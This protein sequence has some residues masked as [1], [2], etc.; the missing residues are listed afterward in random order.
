MNETE[1]T[2][3]RSRRSLMRDAAVTGASIAGAVAPGLAA[4][5]EAGR[6][7]KRKRSRKP[8]VV[9]FLTDQERVVQHFPENWENEHLP[10]QMKLRKKGVT[11]GNA[12]CSACQ[13]SPSRASL[14]TGFFPAQHGVVDVQTYDYDPASANQANL[15]SPDDMPNLATIMAEAGYDVV[16]KGK[17]H[18]SK[19]A[20]WEVPGDPVEWKTSDVTPYGFRR[21]NPPDGGDQPG[22]EYIG[23]G[24][25]DNDGRFMNGTDDQQ[26]VLDFIASRKGRK[27]PFCLIVSLVNPHD[28]TEFPG[29]GTQF[30]DDGYDDSW[31]ES[32]GIELPP[33]YGED[34]AAAG[35][36][37]AQQVLPA[38]LDFYLGA[39]QSE[40]QKVQYVNFYGNLMKI[41]DGYVGD[42]VRALKDAGHYRNT[43]FIRSSDHGEMGMAHGG[44]RQK[45]LVAYEEALRVPMFYVWPKRIPAGKRSDALVSHVDLLPT[46]ASLVGVPKQDMPACQ[47]K[48][49]SKTVMNPEQSGPNEYVLFTYDDV[50]GGV[51]VPPYVGA[52]H[53]VAYRDSRYKIVR[54]RDE[55][56]N[57]DP[58]EWEFYDLQADPFEEVNI[59]FT[60]AGNAT[61]A[62]YRNR[63]DQAIQDRLQPL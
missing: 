41:V 23:A 59:A 13:C 43:I 46:L 38:Q 63:L 14:F 18:I 61:L 26:G 58:D 19:P 29:I 25:A 54:Y 52:N 40:E 37:N 53:I 35:K 7:G 1:S 10:A 20:S 49:Y 5:A 34:L 11:F 3:R 50:Y 32:T 17:W 2:D 55:R 24:T 22:P 60:D 57:P 21:W 16:Y 56:E 45:T 12:F 30:A 15:P 62:D 9:L 6:K 4:P 36:P 39:F 28:I 44:L 27:K 33:T 48:D 8:N 31:L 42:T 51:P 47:G